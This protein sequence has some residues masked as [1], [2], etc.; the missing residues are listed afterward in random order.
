MNKIYCFCFCFD[1]SN[2]LQER[3]LTQRGAMISETTLWAFICQ[4]VTALR[5][6]HALDLACRVIHPLR[7]LWTSPNRIRINCVGVLDILEQDS[8]KTLQELQR[9]D[10]LYVLFF[11]LSLVLSSFFLLFFL[12]EHVRL[13]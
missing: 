5:A 4:L 3:Y 7:I 6:I 1:Q 8:Q 12:V 9:E 13:T 10:I 2:R 11:L